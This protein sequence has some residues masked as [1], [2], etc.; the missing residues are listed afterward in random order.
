MDKGSKAGSRS[1]QTVEELLD[2]DLDIDFETAYNMI[3]GT[4]ELLEEEGL[5][6]HGC[7][8]TFGD[9]GLQFG[10]SGRDELGLDDGG[11]RG[12][13]PHN[14]LSVDESYAI[15]N[16]LNSLMPSPKS[17]L[18]APQ[19]H[20]DE[21]TLQTEPSLSHTAF[22]PPSL[23]PA[24]L[25]Q[26]TLPEPVSEDANN[27]DY[28]PNPISLPEI[29]I[30]E[31]EIPNEIRSNRAKVRRWKHVYCEKQRRTIFRQ[32][33][34]DLISM[35]RF[36]RPTDLEISCLRGPRACTE[37]R[38]R[39]K[40]APGDGKRIPKH[41]LLRYIAEDIELLLLANRELENLL[42]AAAKP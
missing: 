29:K 12:M 34:D 14:L 18:P 27:D 33:F 19:L 26:P 22:S 7:D 40:R 37:D 4:V 42:S 39:K 24:T 41:V 15:E 3:Y 28:R 23:T 9:A 1:H 16:F 17:T 5:P 11:V 20:L 21:S 32:A 35:V 8:G 13:L 10:E 31:H 25:S 6:L 30:P 38:V 2:V 36:P